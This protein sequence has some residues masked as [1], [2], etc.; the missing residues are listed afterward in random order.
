VR[1]LVIIAGIV[2]VPLSAHAM[3]SDRISTLVA[4]NHDGSAAL[5]EHRTYRDGDHSL[6]YTVVAVG[7]KPVSA[8]ITATMRA[9]SKDDEQ[10][11]VADCTA[12]AKQ[13]ATALAADHFSGVDVHADECKRAR[14]GVVSIASD[15][16]REVE[17]SWVALPQGRTP[18]AREQASW[19][20]VKQLAPSYQPFVPAAGCAAQHDTIDVAN[21]SGKLV[22]VFSAWTCNTPVRV[23]VTGFVPKGDTFEDAHLFD[24]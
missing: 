4:W 22:L 17:Q 8:G 6:G 18:T 10:I 12:A 7:A 23:T 16:Q 20:V 2:A 24:N 1:S 15:A 3:G 21:R 9:D 5:I 14:N 13:L 11:A 19:D